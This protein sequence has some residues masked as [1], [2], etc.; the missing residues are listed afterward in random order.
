MNTA[1][2]YTTAIGARAAAI[3]KIETTMMDGARALRDSRLPSDPYW[4]QREIT[5]HGVR[6][7]WR[8]GRD[9]VIWAREGVREDSASVQLV[10]A[11]DVTPEILRLVHE[12]ATA[13]TAVIVRECAVRL[14][15]YQAQTDAI[16]VAYA[17]V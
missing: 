14:A 8:D 17:R 7:I 6:L 1:T 12:I 2:L 3:R 5:A 16:I 11:D 9:P 15:S 13:E 10:G 4:I